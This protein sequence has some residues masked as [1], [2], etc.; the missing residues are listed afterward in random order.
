MATRRKPR[1]E[2]A[3]VERLDA[4][5]RA[6][7]TAAVMFHTVLAGLQG[8][9]ATEE[10]ALDLIERFGPL[11]AGDLARRA[12]LAPASVTALLDRLEKKGF[13]R[14]TANPADRRRVLVEFDRS[15]LVRLAPLFSDLVRE[16]H[17]MYA[18][19]SRAELETVLRF[20][21]EATR[22]QSAATGR[23]TARADSMK[24]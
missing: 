15:S 1:V 7:S 13:A 2:R 12:G 24:R 6:M 5:G 9:S 18:G 4:A 20:L 14:R 23:L 17:E 21:E 22:R 19:Y 8:L 3:L 16:M 11:T 10:K